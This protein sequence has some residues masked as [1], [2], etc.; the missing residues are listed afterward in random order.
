MESNSGFPEKLDALDLV[1]TALKEHEKRLDQLS[2][3]LE[4]LTNTLTLDRLEGITDSLAPDKASAS[5]ARR[6]ERRADV[7]ARAS[8]APRRAEA[9]EPEA[10]RG[11]P[12][13]VCA[14]WSDFKEKCT[15]AKIVTFEAKDDSFNVY[16]AVGESI[17]RYSEEL[18]DRRLRLTEE[19]SRLSI[20]KTP[21]LDLGSLQLIIGGRLRCGLGFSVKTRRVSLSDGQ[22]VL[23]LSY[24]F[25][26]D[27]VKDY[28]SDELSVQRK[29]V[30]EGRITR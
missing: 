17:F 15:N 16:C 21:R 18:P 27:E 28:L 9:H 3:R 23:E 1:I 20:E 12:F 4:G 8:P 24:G 19:A 7:G 6:D 29:D 10:V 22:S 30:V 2:H 26:P 25:S 14:N 11:T 5:S 13:I